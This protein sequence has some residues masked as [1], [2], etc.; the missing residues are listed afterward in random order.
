MEGFAERFGTVNYAVRERER[1]RER[2]MIGCVRN[3]DP[4]LGSRHL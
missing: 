3:F 2:E 4:R 1:E